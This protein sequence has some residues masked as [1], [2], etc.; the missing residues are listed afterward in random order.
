VEEILITHA[1]GG[2]GPE[3]ALNRAIGAFS[4]AHTKMSGAEMGFVEI[5]L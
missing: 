2:R 1:R 3:N 5:P 4:T